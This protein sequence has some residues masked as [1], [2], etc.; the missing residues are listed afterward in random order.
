MDVRRFYPS[1]D[2]IGK[3]LVSNVGGNDYRLLCCVSWGLRRL[4]F[5]TLLTH[6]EHDR[7]DPEASC[8]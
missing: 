4:F 7:T 3:T 1:A 5:R 2:Q 8:P 6:A